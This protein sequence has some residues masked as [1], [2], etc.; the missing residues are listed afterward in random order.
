VGPS[1]VGSTG[2]EGRAVSGTLLTTGDTGTDKQEAL[3]L[4]LLG[5]SDGVGVVRV[6]T[7]NDDVTL[8]EVRLKLG[9]E[10]VD[11]LSGLDEEND[12]SGSLEVLAELLNG[13]GA[14]DV[15]A[16]ELGAIDRMNGAAHPW[17]RSPG[18][19]RPWRWFCPSASI[20][21]FGRCGRKR[22]SE[23]TGCRRRR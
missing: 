21:R 7:V 22:V 9:N 1:G 3:G 16:C 14:D 23:L 11:G 12:S 2:H 5:S 20:I 18:S 10:V 13:L 6:T 4:E 8:L 15:G 19:G 17:P